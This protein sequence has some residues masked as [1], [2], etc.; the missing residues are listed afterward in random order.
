MVM[1]VFV[2]W[3]VLK[4]FSFYFSAPAELSWR[5]ADFLLKSDESEGVKVFMRRHEPLCPERDAK[6]V[7]FLQQYQRAYLLYLEY[8]V[9]ER[10]SKVNFW[11]ITAEV[12]ILHFCSISVFNEWRNTTNIQSWTCWFCIWLFNELFNLRL[13]Y[14]TVASTTRLLSWEWSDPVVTFWQFAESSLGKV[15]KASHPKKSNL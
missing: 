11:K 6:I 10:D 13:L 8:L 14:R 2:I 3:L 5:Y 9:S 15:L 12:T 1:K 7:N 4:A